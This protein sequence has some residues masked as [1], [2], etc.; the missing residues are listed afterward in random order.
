MHHIQQ[1]ELAFEMNVT[2]DTRLAAHPM[3]V[4]ST[5]SVLTLSDILPA[6]YTADRAILA[7]IP[8]APEPGVAFPGLTGMIATVRKESLDVFSDAPDVLALDTS[9]VS[10]SG[11]ECNKVGVGFEAFRCA[12]VT[13]WF[14]LP[15]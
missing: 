11:L 3:S 10:L 4:S 9:M 13:V 6:R 1:A 5:M 15:A 8:A 7:R 2:V 12:T 14:S